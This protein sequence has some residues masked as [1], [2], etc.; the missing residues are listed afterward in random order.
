MYWNTVP[1]FNT[2]ARSNSRAWCPICQTGDTWW[3]TQRPEGMEVVGKS[4]CPNSHHG[5]KYHALRTMSPIIP[6]RGIISSNLQWNIPQG[7]VIHFSPLGEGELLS[8][9]WDPIFL[10]QAFWNALCLEWSMHHWNRGEGGVPG[11]AYPAPGPSLQPDRA[12]YPWPTRMVCT[13]RTSS[14]SCQPPSA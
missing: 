8:L 14:L 5:S 10:L 7:C 9:P 6:G 12:A 11:L 2:S 4:H 3:D 1:G 13:T